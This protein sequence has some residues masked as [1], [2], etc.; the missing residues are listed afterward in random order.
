MFSCT[1]I[2]KPVTEEKVAGNELSFEK[3]K[4]IKL[5]CPCYCSQ[6]PAVLRVFYLVRNGKPAWKWRRH[7]CTIV[8]HALKPCRAPVNRY[9]SPGTLVTC[10]LV[11]DGFFPILCTQSCRVPLWNREFAPYTRRRIIQKSQNGSF[12]TYWEDKSFFKIYHRKALITLVRSVPGN[13]LL[14]KINPMLQ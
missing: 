2:C 14:Q 5:L 9:Q 3:Q 13:L 1:Q 12:L 11:G 8:P 7:S 6:G 4:I 10:E